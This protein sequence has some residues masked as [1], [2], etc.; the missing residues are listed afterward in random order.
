MSANDQTRQVDVKQTEPPR[1]CPQC[2]RA[3]G[4]AQTL[5]SHC[6]ER[7]LDQSYCPTCEHF[8]QR[9]AGSDCP[10]HDLPLEDQPPSSR[11]DSLPLSDVRWVTVGIFADALKSEAP[12]IR[13]EAEGIPTF[14][15][16]E[17]MGSHSMYHVA[18][19]GV[20][21]QVP[22]PLASEARI[23]LSQTWSSVDTLENLDDAWDD[24]SPDPGSKRRSVMRGLILLFLFGP[25][26]L[27][28]LAKL[29]GP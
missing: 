8:W 17:R 11:A 10:K 4:S 15:E 22:E 7:L 1:Y 27:A 12:R 29:L 28:V 21:L 19:G 6:G 14:V 24:L 16:G 3:A 5:C 25:L 13:L 9:P 18:V 23:L 20:K 26:A 2:N